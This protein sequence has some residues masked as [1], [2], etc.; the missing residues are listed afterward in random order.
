MM[1]PASNPDYYDNLVKELDEAPNRSRFQSWLNKWK[2]F[3]RFSWGDTH[4]HLHILGVTAV[5][6]LLDRIHFLRG[7]TS[8][9]CYGGTQP[10]GPQIHRAPSSEDYAS[11]CTNLYEMNISLPGYNLSSEM[12]G[13]KPLAFRSMVHV[14]FIWR[15]CTVSV[16]IS[17]TRRR[18]Y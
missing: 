16:S 1:R 5:L 14:L 13:C 4:T 15:M 11:I 7:Y 8:E 12:V 10:E 17:P 18:D 6:S 3:L 2:G 9:W